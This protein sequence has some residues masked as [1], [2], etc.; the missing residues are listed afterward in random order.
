MKLFGEREEFMQA[1]PPIGAG[2]RRKA[3][4]FEGI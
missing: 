4:L 2:F 1:F 3:D